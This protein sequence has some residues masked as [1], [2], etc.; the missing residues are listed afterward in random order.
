MGRPNILDSRQIL[1]FLG[2]QSSLLDQIHARQYEDN[3]LVALRDRVLLGVDEKAT[4]DSD[5]VLRFDGRLYI[6]R[7]GGLM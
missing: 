5:R 7:V 2:T 6:P 1:A 3:S 4:L